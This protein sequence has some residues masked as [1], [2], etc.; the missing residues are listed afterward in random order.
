L[1]LRRAGEGDVFSFT[2]RSIASDQARSAYTGRTRP[3]AE[4]DG[5]RSI[6]ELVPA[7]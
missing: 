6:V 2:Y 4:N 3:L 5:A 1:V 7:T